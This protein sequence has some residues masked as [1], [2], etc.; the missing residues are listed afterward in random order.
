[1]KNPTSPAKAPIVH[2]DLVDN[3]GYITITVNITNQ[4]VDRFMTKLLPGASVRIK[5]FY[6]KKKMQYKRGDADYYIQLTVQSTVETID[7]VC[8]YQKLIPNTRICQLIQSPNSYSIGTL[9]VIV[10]A[11][12]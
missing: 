11:H 8:S 6:L 3:H 2:A 9:G 10:V 1:M 7:Q 5:Y 12:K 4:L